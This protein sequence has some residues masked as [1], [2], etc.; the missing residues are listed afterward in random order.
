MIGNAIVSGTALE[1][2]VIQKSPPR[3]GRN[4]LLWQI[5]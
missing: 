4:M 1:G 2:Q 3:C 5:N